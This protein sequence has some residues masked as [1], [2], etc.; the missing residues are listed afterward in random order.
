M[1][2][3]V[4]VKRQSPASGTVDHIGKHEFLTMPREG[5]IV[6]I[7]GGGEGEVQRV[8]HLIGLGKAPEIAI[9]IDD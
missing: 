3:K 2:I 6:V 8:E 9:F 7:E 4:S 5:E 1:T